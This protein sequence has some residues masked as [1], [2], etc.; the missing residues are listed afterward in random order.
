MRNY[1]GVAGQI[2]L[3]NT[4]KDYIDKLLAVFNEVWRVLK[5]EGSLWINIGDSYAGRGRSTVRHQKSLMGIP[6]QFALA[7]ADEWIF[8]QDIIWHKPNPMPESINDRF[9]KSHEY[10]FFFVKQSKYYFDHES[11]QELANFDGR[12]DT[13]YKGGKKDMAGGA[14]N[15]WPTMREYLEEGT[16]GTS[17]VLQPMRNKRDVWTIASEPSTEKHYAIFPQKLIMP[18]I[19]CGC[20][21]NGVV[22]DP[23][24]GSGT[25]AVVATKLRRKYIGCEINPEYVRIAEKR[26]SNEKGL[27][28]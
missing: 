17:I 13:Q 25:T 12:K 22:L 10:L 19:L 6:Y 27:F 18:C 28:A 15:R 23:F 4:P 24:M 16:D 1:G 20:P 7:M 8:R 21:E 26:I 5:D 11:S 9:T 14:H 3:E 2:G